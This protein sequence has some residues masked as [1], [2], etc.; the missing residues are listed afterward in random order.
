MITARHSAPARREEAGL[1]RPDCPRCGS[2][3]VVPAPSGGPSECVLELRGG[4]EVPIGAPPDTSQDW[5]CRFCGYRWPR[6]QVAVRGLPGSTRT[7]DRV[8]A[9][10]DP[11]PSDPLPDPSNLEPAPAILLTG[12]VAPSDPPAVPEATD[13]TALAAAG[14]LRRARRERALTLSEAAKAT[15][16]WERYLRALESDAPLEEFPA[17][18][19]ARFFLREYAD[20]LGLDPAVMV[21]EFDTRHP[22]HEEQAF[23]PL[24]DPR[25]RRKIVATVLAVVSALTLVGIALANTGR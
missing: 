9:E 14:L 12:P 4:D 17:P 8:E 11:A 2:S 5:L 13:E 20:F 19:Y 23:E 22:V 10:A 16:I 18:A 7:E 1:P 15:R 3:L 6:V 21:S 24:P 25:P